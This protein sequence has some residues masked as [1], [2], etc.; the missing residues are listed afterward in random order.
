MESG[1]E[2]WMRLQWKEIEFQGEVRAGA[3]LGGELGQ[4]IGWSTDWEGHARG[5]VEGPRALR[6]DVS[7]A[8][9]AGE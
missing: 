1:L 9:G 6:M 3:P 2:G 7:E 4:P 5:H 8:S